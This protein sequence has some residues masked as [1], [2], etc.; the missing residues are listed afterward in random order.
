M[1]RIIT[2]GFLLPKDLTDALVAYLVKAYKAKSNQQLGR[3]I[4]QKL[5]YFAKASGVPLPF[6]FEIYH[7]GPFSQEIFEV[8]DGLAIDEVVTDSSADPGQ[9][10]YRPGPNCDHLLGFFAEDIERYSTDLDRVAAT[11]S[12]LN[13]SS[14]ELVSTIHYINSSLRQWNKQAA[15]KEEVVEKVY[16]IKGSKFSRDS[17]D[18]VYDVL[19]KARLLS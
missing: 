6:S 3:T 2:E 17:V 11:F 15:S 1:S 8:V 9:S 19:L 7:Y 12:E 16:Q 5:C 10:D 18:R 13:P 4:L 14:M